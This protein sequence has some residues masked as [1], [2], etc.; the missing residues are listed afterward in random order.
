M[1][2]RSRSSRPR[3]PLRHGRRPKMRILVVVGN[4][5]VVVEGD[6][7]AGR[8]ATAPAAAAAPVAPA[9]ASAPSAASRIRLARLAGLRLARLLRQAV[10]CDAGSLAFS[11][12]V[13]WRQN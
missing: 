10:G 13:A 6:G 12:A 3:S 4:G 5:D 2:R 9:P 11:W 8:S 7:M 1:E